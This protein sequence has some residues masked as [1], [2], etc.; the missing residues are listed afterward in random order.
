M[1]AIAFRSDSNAGKFFSLQTPD[2]CC[3]C[4]FVRSVRLVSTGVGDLRSLDLL[5]DGGAG[6]EER[7]ELSSA[8]TWTG[9]NERPR[10]SAWD[11]RLGIERRGALEADEEEDGRGFWER[12]EERG[13]EEAC[14]VLEEVERLEADEREE[15][16]ERWR[17]VEVE[18]DGMM[19]R[20]E[21]QGMSCT[22]W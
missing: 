13:L 1:A 3:K 9:P 22:L 8:M 14:G 21:R 18:V 2:S 11:G 17:E 15:E 12:E 16:E 5:R 19:G 10:E 4:A 20:R 6:R 7:D